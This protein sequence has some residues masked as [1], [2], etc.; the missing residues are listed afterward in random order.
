MYKNKNL[1]VQIITYK[2]GN[3]EYLFKLLKIFDIPL[4]VVVLAPT[5]KYREILN[6][7]RKRKRP[8]IHFL[9]KKNRKFLS[10]YHILVYNTARQSYMVKYRGK[11]NYPKLVFLDHGSGDRNYIYNEKILDFDLICLAGNKVLDMCRSSADF[12]KTN[13]QV[14]GYQKFETV[15]F[16]NK[17]IEIFKNNK[18]TILYNPHF[19]K[20]ISSYYKKGKE[21]LDFFYE[22]D[23]Y[24]LIFAPH[25]ILF[26]RKEHLKREEFNK[27]YNKKNNIHIDLGSVN[28]VNMQYVLLADVYLGDVSSQVYE[29][30]IKPRPCI[31]VNSHNVDWEN[32]KHYAN[33]KLGKVI[34]DISELDNLLKTKDVWSK[35]YIQKQKEI[36]YYTF[37]D[38]SISASKKIADEIIKLFD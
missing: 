13:I 34:N 35:D 12:S 10:K 37:G 7:L 18:P 32:D 29:F 5:Y 33:W 22:N 15:K 27:K 2:D 3:H 11:K 19:L 25:I 6:K 4:D 9:F 17:N 14:C 20:G 1:D 16:E 23:N 24:N 31:F 26:N 38:Q 30:L 8:S 21:V 28:S 36:F